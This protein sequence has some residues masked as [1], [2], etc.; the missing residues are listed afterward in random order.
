MPQCENGHEMD[1]KD[2][3]ICSRCGSHVE[4]DIQ[5]AVR[6][7]IERR[8]EITKREEK[9]MSENKFPAYTLKGNFSLEEVAALNEIM[10]Q[11]EPKLV[12]ADFNFWKI[13]KM[14]NGWTMIL[15]SSWEVNG[16]L[17]GNMN[18]IAHYFQGYYCTE[19]G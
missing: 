7:K 2:E 16:C 6:L 3:Y 19:K 10:A 13:T 15:R 14:R 11:Y 4:T 1:N 12:D 9:T 5:K 8:V 17:C 18:D